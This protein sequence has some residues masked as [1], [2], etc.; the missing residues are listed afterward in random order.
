MNIE[1]G[2]Q[3]PRAKN[4]VERSTRRKAKMIRPRLELGTFCVLD[5]C[6]NQLRHR[7]DRENAVPSNLKPKRVSR[8]V[9]HGRRKIGAQDGAGPKTPDSQ[10]SDV[11]G[12]H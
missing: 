8:R 11:W 2:D 5:R 9:D 6:D 1:M 7:T 12:V 10:N 3:G 4:E